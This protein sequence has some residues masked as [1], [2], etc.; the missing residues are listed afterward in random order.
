MFGTAK[1]LSKCRARDK[2]H[3][4]STPPRVLKAARSG[5]VPIDVH[6]LSGTAVET[7]PMD[8]GRRHHR[9]ALLRGAATLEP[10]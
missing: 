4:S 5:S 10:L 1:G 6:L 8:A 3:S 2:H 9:T 7:R